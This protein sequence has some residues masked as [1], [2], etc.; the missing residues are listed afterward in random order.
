[1]AAERERNSN[2]G[3]RKSKYEELRKML[4]RKDAVEKG[5]C[6]ETREEKRLKKNDCKEKRV[7]KS[8]AWGGKGVRVCKKGA[9]KEDGEGMGKKMAHVQLACRPAPARLNTVLCGGGMTLFSHNSSLA[10][11]AKHTRASVPQ[12]LQAQSSRPAHILLPSVPPPLGIPLHLGH[13]AAAVAVLIAV[14]LVDIP[15][16]VASMRR[17]RCWRRCWRRRRRWR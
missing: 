3:L 5:Y 8:K 12:S 7:V 1:M 2:C 13:A 11:D 16:I 6:R 14:P 4:K 10:T 15:A 9:C 17:C